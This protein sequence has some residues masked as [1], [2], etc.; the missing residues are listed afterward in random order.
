MSRL[1]FP[2][3]SISR[4]IVFNLTLLGLLIAI[5]LFGPMI[6]RVDPTSISITGRFAAPSQAHPLG[7][8]EFGRDVLSRLIHGGRIS[9]SVAFAAAA[10]AAVGGSIAGLVGGYLGRFWEFATLRL[11]DVVLAFP[12]ILL[13]LLVASLFGPSVVT[14][15]SVLSVLYMPD[16]ARIA[17]GETLSVKRMEY[18]EAMQA[19]GAGT[20]RIL[21][22]TLFPNIAGPLLVQ[23]SLTVSHAII[24][25][26]GLS[27]LGLGIVPPTPSWGLMIRTARSFM[28]VNPIGLLW[29]SLCLVL[30]IFVVNR[31]CDSLQ[32][33]FDPRSSTRGIPFLIG[34]R[35]SSET[36]A[37]VPLV[38]A[39]E[40]ARLAV[41]N[42]RV[43]FATRSGTTTAVHDVSIDIKPGEI[44]AL[45]GESGSGKSVTSL[46]ING[47]LP[48]KIARIDNGR[49]LIT[50]RNGEVF[51]TAH[52]DH[53]TLRRLRGSEVATVFQEPMTSLNPVYRIGDQIVEAIL[54]NRDVGREEAGKI[55][56]SMLQKVG[57]SDPQR[58]L[59]QFPHELSGGMR[60]R[61][62]IAQALSCDPSLLIA[63]EPTT[64]LDVTIQA[65]ILQLIKSLQE[66]S[67]G[68]MSVLFVTHNLGIV[69]QIADRVAVM[70]AGRVVETGP[71]GQIFAHPRHPYTR[72]LLECIPR[73]GE[74]GG[75][76][77]RLVTI[78]G[79]VPSSLNGIPGCA[80]AERCDMVQ[81]SCHEAVP[82][83]V[84]VTSGLHKSRCF[85]WQSI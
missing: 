18:V 66:E 13:A 63:D 67:C 40:K 80:F 78:P 61:A 41:E 45:V 33:A 81:A 19:L 2:S 62:L 43:Q 20:L 65:E 42:L 29:P 30:T 76:G 57:M 73:L 6:W 75:E 56:L 39:E 48:A 51:D 55:A 25:E 44:L 35:R 1:R 74:A 27:F 69:A 83:L 64:A 12:P 32:E 3:G 14:L 50:T 17:Y 79:T 9:L 36:T 23:F 82:P 53:K 22:R 7:Q 54:A 4:P 34:R 52:A 59:K 49:I 72:R 11:A 68:R 15:I 28:E 60:Q 71:T 10:I 58:R 5:A 77:R 85:F 26:A 46:S 16:F 21:F 37:P 38:P 8:D 47:L 70:Y 31:L 84:E 24:V